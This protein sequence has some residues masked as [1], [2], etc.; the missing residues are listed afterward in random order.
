MLCVDQILLINAI[1]NDCGRISALI[2]RNEIFEI[3]NII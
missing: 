2:Y 1:G 3:H